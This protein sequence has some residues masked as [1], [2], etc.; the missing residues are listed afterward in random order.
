MSHFENRAPLKPVLGGR[1]L[2]GALG[3]LQRSFLSRNIT[4]HKHGLLTKN[5]CAVHGKH[6]WSSRDGQLT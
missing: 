2:Y 3:S 6:L 1:A 4:P 5:E